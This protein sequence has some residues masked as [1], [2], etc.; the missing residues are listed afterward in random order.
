MTFVRAALLL[1]VSLYLS[2]A[3]RAA[4]T[5][6]VHG[7][8]DAFSVP[9]VRLAWGILRGADESRTIVVVRIVTDSN[10]FP[11]AAV[12]GVDPFTDRKKIQLN[13]TPV[14]SGLELRL[15]RPSFGDLP[16]TDFRFF[17]SAADAD[18]DTPQL[19]V[20]YLGVPDTTPEFANETA[21]DKYL[22]D[23]L[24]RARLQKGSR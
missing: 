18:S 19:I 12:T 14:R 6:E 16:R 11:L 23:R 15:P 22:T 20:Y 24:E 13:A 3:A 8:A 4:D 21:L 1:V 7:S 17:H 9:G 10:I 5:R 2:D